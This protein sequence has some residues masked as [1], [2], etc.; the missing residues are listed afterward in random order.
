MLKIKA[1]V[2]ILIFTILY[3]LVFANAVKAASK[4]RFGNTKDLE[5]K[6]IPDSTE[7]ISGST[8]TFTLSLTNKSKRSV[9]VNYP[10]GRQWD[11]VIYKDKMPIFRWSNGYTWHEAPHSIALKPG[12]SITTQL[13]WVPVN[14][15]GI[16]LIQG[17]YECA[18]IVTSSPKSFI[19]N[20]ASFNLIPPS[21]LEKQT[22][23]TRLNQ[24]FEI[25]LPKSIGD[26]NLTWKIAYKNNDNRINTTSRK[27]TDKNLIITFIP[28]RIGHVEFYIYAYPENL[29]E[30]FSLERRYYR[31]EVE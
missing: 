24:P 16:P 6:I 20:E 3:L 21:S 7:F 8:A 19:S 22:I 10:N 28:K 31:I 17:K 12:E 15:N 29:N 30:N 5:I 13:S 4:Y 26:T 23:K 11:M 2:L 1:K 25:E 27:I 18:A 9:K 14:K